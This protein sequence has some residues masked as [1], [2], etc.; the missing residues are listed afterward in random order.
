METKKVEIGNFTAHLVSYI[1]NGGANANYSGNACQGCGK[2]F[3]CGCQRD[4][5]YPSLCKE[6]AD[7][8]RNS[9]SGK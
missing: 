3:T 6:C 7:K 2:V 1:S 5:Q 8:K 9:S 4:S